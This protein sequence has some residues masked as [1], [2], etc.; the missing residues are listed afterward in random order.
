MNIEANNIETNSKDSKK[1]K[2]Y[3]ILTAA[4]KVFAEQGFSSATVAQIAREAGVADG[5]I[6]L[7]F[8]NK[9]DIL[10]QFFRYKT[11]QIFKRFKEEID[12]VDEPVEKLSCLIRSHLEEF[13]QDRNMA[14]I[15]Q[16]EI[17]YRRNIVAQIIDVSNMYLELVTAIIEQ[18]Q[19][20]DKLR[21]DLFTG[22]VK[23]FILGAVEEVINTWVHSGGKYDLVS[24]ADPLIDLFINGIGNHNY[25]HY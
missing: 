9:D 24:M 12:S 22:L 11:K 25:N 13:Q 1:D 6:Y 3:L 21:K 23:R 16:S 8:K 4:S 19:V 18:G 5:T 20:E 15:F 7:Y 2:Y 17:R 10:F 14:I